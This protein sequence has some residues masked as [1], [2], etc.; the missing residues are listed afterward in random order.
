MLFAILLLDEQL[1][2][3]AMFG[4]SLVVAGILV[5]TGNPFRSAS[6]RPL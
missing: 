2:V 4:A 1:T 5:V 3:A 6:R